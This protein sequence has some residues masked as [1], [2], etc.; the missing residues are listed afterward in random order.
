MNCRTDLGS[1][2][3]YEIYSGDNRGMLAAESPGGASSQVQDG[4]PES[5]PALELIEMANGETIW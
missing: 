3:R 2:R 5:G 4:I 1:L